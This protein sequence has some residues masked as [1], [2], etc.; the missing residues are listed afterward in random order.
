MW[1]RLNYDFGV[2]S[3]G[4]CCGLQRDPCFGLLASAGRQALV[5]RKQVCC[6]EL[7]H[8]QQSWCAYSHQARL[9]GCRCCANKHT[10]QTR[11]QANL[12]LR[13]RR[14]PGSHHVV[15]R[16]RLRDAL[17]REGR[18]VAA[19][20]DAPLRIPGALAVAHEHDAAARGDGRQRQR[21]RV[22]AVPQRREVVRARPGPLLR[23]GG[24]GPRH[25]AA[26]QGH[27]R[28]G[29]PGGA[30]RKWRAD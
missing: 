6:G 16:L 19:A 4:D 17:G 7:S 14:R 28:P 18:E 25:A 20:L 3:S 24:R 30:A 15:C 13:S 26:W 5:Q 11:V 8:R 1:V 2:S 22:D 9:A 21:R 27:P 23:R 10:G 12:P 29:R